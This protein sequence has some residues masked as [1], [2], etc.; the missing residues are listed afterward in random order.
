VQVKHGS[1]ARMMLRL[2][3]I[4]SV[5]GAGYIRSQEQVIQAGGEQGWGGG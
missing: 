4:Q 3:W 2:A 5:W 1:L